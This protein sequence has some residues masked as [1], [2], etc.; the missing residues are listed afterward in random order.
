MTARTKLLTTP[1]YAVEQSLKRLGAD[2]RT[3][4]LRRNLTIE[5]VAGKIGTGLRTVSDAEKG[6]P[7]T[8]V[9]VYTAILWAL[10]LLS[11]LDEVARPENDA[12][13]QSLALAKERGR[14]RARTELSNDF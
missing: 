6:K 7:S 1:P 13:G 4:R 2:L 9:A 5:D 8:T 10:D 12:E 14:A 11:Q 3:A